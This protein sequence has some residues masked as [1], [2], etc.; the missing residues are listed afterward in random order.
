MF[1][2]GNYLFKKQ[3]LNVQII[4]NKIC[5]KDFCGSLWADYVLNKY[6]IASILSRTHE[7]IRMEWLISMVNTE[8]T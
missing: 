2:W 6:T 3:T 5:L 4:L 8:D 7:I 1:F